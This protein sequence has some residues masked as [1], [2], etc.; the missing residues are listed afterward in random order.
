MRQDALNSEDLRLI[1]N[2][3][4]GAW[5]WLA[6]SDLQSLAEQRRIGFATALGGLT[7]DL[8]AG[9]TNLQDEMR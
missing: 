6:S 2:W 4:N 3:F 9:C 7:R 8:V 1:S 5:E